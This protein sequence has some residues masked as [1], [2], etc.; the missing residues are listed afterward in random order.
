MHGQ[1]KHVILSH[2]SIRTMSISRISGTSSSKSVG[3]AKKTDKA[4]GPNFKSMVDAADD[5]VDVA[6][7][8]TAAPV[9]AVSALLFAQESGDQMAGQQKNKRRAND[10]LDEMERL[11]LAILDGS[12]PLAQLH[13]IQRMVN[14]Q[15]AQ[16]NDPDLSA[17]L[18]DIELRA[19]V[20]LAKLGL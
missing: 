3:K 5:V 7:V 20:E 16:M 10:I 13:N 17:L 1:I 18:D 4:G 2:R 15:R 19:A 14:Q 6:P 11:R 12:I 9:G 8:Q